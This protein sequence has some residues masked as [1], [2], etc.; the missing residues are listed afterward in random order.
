[1]TADMTV[2]IQDPFDNMEQW[3]C[4]EVSLQRLIG[5]IVPNL[6]VDSDLQLTG[7]TMALMLMV[8]ELPSLIKCQKTHRIAMFYGLQ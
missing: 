6:L 4:Q 5:V 1:M 2:L 3:L 8:M 7:G